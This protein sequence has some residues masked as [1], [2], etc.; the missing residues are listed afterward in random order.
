MIDLP[1]GAR[2]AGKLSWPSPDDFGLQKRSI[3]LS[4]ID[5]IS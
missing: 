3:L 4:D 1:S 2:K 5:A